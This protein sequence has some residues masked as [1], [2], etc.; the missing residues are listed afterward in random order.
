MKHTYALRKFARVGP[1]PAPASSQT[2]FIPVSPDLGES[3]AELSRIV[4]QQQ[5][6]IRRAFRIPP[7]M[8]KP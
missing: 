1:M 8:V 7:E 4:R 6:S 2:F 5:E 3:L